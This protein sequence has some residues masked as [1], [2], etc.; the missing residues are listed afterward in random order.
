MTINNIGCPETNV[1]S[2][3][4]TYAKIIIFCQTILFVLYLLTMPI[5]YINRGDMSNIL[6]RITT[7]DCVMVMFIGFGVLRNGWRWKCPLVFWGFI[8]Y[9]AALSFATLVAHHY[10]YAEYPVNSSQHGW[11]ADMAGHLLCAGALLA[12][13]DYLAS[14]SLNS[15]IILLRFFVAAMSILGIVGIWDMAAHI[16]NFPKLSQYYGLFFNY[17][18]MPDLLINDVGYFIGT[19]RHFP[20]AWYFYFIV[21]ILAMINMTMLPKKSKIKLLFGLFLWVPFTA[22]FLTFQRTAI[23]G[24]IA[25]T[26]FVFVAALIEKVYL[27]ERI[28]QLAWIW[29]I[30]IIIVATFCQISPGFVERL[31]YKF[32][33]HNTTKKIDIRENNSKENNISKI[34]TVKVGGFGSYFSRNGFTYKNYIETWYSFLKHPC[35]YGFSGYTVKTTRG[36]SIHGVYPKIYCEGGVL[37]ILSAIFLFVLL[38]YEPMRNRKF[39]PHI[40]SIVYVYIP[41]LLALFITF[42]HA[43]YLRNREFWLLIAFVLALT[44]LTKK[45]KTSNE[46]PSDEDK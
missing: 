2:E 15:K 46:K 4:T 27:K 30:T 3:M 12:I 35:G 33:G 28:V 45:Q 7:A 9:I 19:F 17:K 24:L 41:F 26:F 31:K 16:Y 8:S 11:R 36:N 21:G 44:T 10:G 14:I 13:Y 32:I 43:Y 39:S 42:F 23:I 25:G 1:V 20:Q 22:V 37:G 34:E 18:N 6:D 29:L 5:T 38:F 40:S